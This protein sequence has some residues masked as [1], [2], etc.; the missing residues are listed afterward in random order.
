MTNNH[1][2]SNSPPPNQLLQLAL[3][4]LETARDPVFWTDPSGRFIY[5]NQSAAA[6]LEY[7]RDQLLTLRV[8]DISPDMPPEGWTAHWQALKAE[9]S[10]IIEAW[11]LTSS[12]R[13]LLLEVSTNY[14]CHNGYEYTCALARDITERR[15]RERE[16]VESRRQFEA[17]FH[18][19]PIGM[20][21][22][23][24]SD[25]TILEVNQALEELIG[26]PRAEQLGRTTIDVLGISASDRQRLIAPIRESGVARNVELRITRKSGEQIDLLVT[27]TRIEFLGQECLL[28]AVLDITAQKKAEAELL[29]AERRFN[30]ALANSP[31]VLYRLNVKS[32]HYEYLSHYVEELLGYPMEQFRL[33]GYEKIISLIHPDDLPELNR[34]FARAEQSKETRVPLQMEYR[35]RK[36]NGDYCWLR[37]H[38][39]LI[40]DGNGDKLAFVGSVFDIT[41]R[42]EQE[43]LLHDREEL[44][45][46]IF[47]SSQAGIMLGNERGDIIFANQ[48]LAAMF[49]RS[50]DEMINSNYMDH[51]HPEHRNLGADHLRRLIAGEIDHVHHERRYMRANG[52]EFWGHLSARRMVSAAGAFLGLVGVIADITEIKRAEETARQSDLRYRR[53]VNQAAAWIWETDPDLRHTFSNHYVETCL[54]YSIEEFYNFGMFEL[55]HPDDHARVAEV[56]RQASQEGAGWRNLTLRWKHRDGS[57]RYLESSGDANFDESGAFTGLSGIDIDVTDRV[58]L[59]EQQDRAQRLESL[60]ELAGGIAHDFNNILTGI[61]GN[62]SFARILIGEEHRAAPRLADSEKA[63]LRAAELTRQLLTFSKGG[64]PVRKALATEPL[65][66]EAISFALRGSS[67]KGELG[68]APDIWLLDADPG[69]MSQVFNN[70]LINARQAMLEGGTVMVRAENCRVAPGDHLHLAAGDYVRIEV[71]DEGTGIPSSDLP[72]IFDPYFTTKEYGTGLGLASVYSIVRHH[73]G[74]ISVDSIC[75][76]GTT[77]TLYLPAAPTEGQT[78]HEAVPS[79]A[80]SPLGGGRI[81]LMDDDDLIRDMAALMLAECGYQVETCADGSEAITLF[82]RARE[83]GIRYAA[84]ILDL[85]VPGGMGGRETVARLRTLDKDVPIIVSSGYSDDPVL[86]DYASYGF[87]GVISKPYSLQTFTGELARLMGGPKCP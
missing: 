8:Q 18:E 3:H 11:T 46:G 69:Q 35:I 75:G 14:L 17:F 85:T 52:K 15:A 62:I 42:K 86:A 77:F 22:T 33:Y 43:R 45:R 41:E 61:I 66:Q 76:Q 60:G 24:L 78:P 65:L 5:I 26:Y 44:L 56:A 68:L 55:L 37:D 2:P 53:L 51:V 72:R 71:T 1:S 13:E 79:A 10:M 64:E 84:I 67:V 87:T 4:T 40:L 16:L 73:G 83:E 57:W 74:Q 29:L 59:Q 82:S 50:L 12:G 30:E 32:G 25:G 48:R 54:S 21:I 23:R 38:S 63:T 9:G 36:A 58:R 28:N 34:Q 31:H 27:S 70:L 7:S 49:G 81:L 20:A 39:T 80:R 6:L 47:E 19:S